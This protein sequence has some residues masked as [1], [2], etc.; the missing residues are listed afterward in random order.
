MLG[1]TRAGLKFYILERASKK[2]R[3]KVRG[4]GRR[5]R[6]NVYQLWDT[7]YIIQY[8][9]Y[10][11][12][13]TLERFQCMNTGQAMSTTHSCHAKWL[14]HSAVHNPHV[15]GTHN[16]ELFEIVGTDGTMAIP[17]VVH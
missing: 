1:L 7:T 15:W 13:D 3:E 11:L 16:C 6:Y 14:V 8:T 10:Q 12:W 2:E 9:V 17:A 4:G 5:A